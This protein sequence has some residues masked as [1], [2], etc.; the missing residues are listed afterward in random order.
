EIEGFRDRTDQTLA[1]L[2]TLPKLPAPLELKT[3]SAISDHAETGTVATSAPAKGV[4]ATL[5]TGQVTLARARHVLRND[6]L[7]IQDGC[8]FVVDQINTA[9]ADQIPAKPNTPEALRN[10]EHLVATLEYA[11]A[12][13]IEI[14]GALPETPQAEA[15]SD[16]A[17][18]RL[19]RAFQRAIETLQ[20]SSKYIDDMDG[21]TGHGRSYAG[22]LKIGMCTALA[23]PIGLIAGAAPAVVGAGLYAMLYG[24]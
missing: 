21:E 8:V 24:K 18:G 2:A 17:A 4:S 9:L 13:M 19:Q 10:W 22:L 15:I 12:A 5:S 11:R 14:Q 6:F 23:V 1:Y 3:G 16:E 20:K 7:S